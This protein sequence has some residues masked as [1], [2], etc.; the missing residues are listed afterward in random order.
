MN[1]KMSYPAINGE[2]VTQGHADYCATNG[3][4]TYIKDDV[5][6][7]FCPRCGADKAAKVAV[8][9]TNKVETIE[10]T[11][12]TVEMERHGSHGFAKVIKGIKRQYR[13]EGF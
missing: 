3:H 10:C 4:A 11:L 5:E 8:A 7:Q 13:C 1:F 9:K 12:T 2:T 6:S